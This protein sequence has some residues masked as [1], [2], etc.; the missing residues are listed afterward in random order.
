M[1]TGTGQVFL[2]GASTVS[3]SRLVIGSGGWTMNSR[4]IQMNQANSATG[5]GSRIELNGPVT[6]N[7][8]ASF[9]V[10]NDNANLRLAEIPAPRSGSGLQH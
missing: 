5:V 9:I 4:T 1:S 2:G 10:L 7:T 3:Q 6:V 8:G